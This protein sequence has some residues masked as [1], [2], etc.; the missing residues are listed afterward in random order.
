MPT[1]W[2]LGLEPDPWQRTK[3]GK[4]VEYRLNK[5]EWGKMAVGDVIEYGREPER[6]EIVRV[7]V[8]ELMRYPT[9][10][11]LL[12]YC[13]EHGYIET[14]RTKEEQLQR[15]EAR[16]P[17]EKQQQYDGVLGIRQRPIAPV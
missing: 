10:A 12:D 15:L 6:V 1:V 7:E 9:F 5:P 17:K 16:Y 8:L 11:E 14:H 4:P 2:H 3:N 13:D